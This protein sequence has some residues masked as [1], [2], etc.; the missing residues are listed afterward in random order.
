M[1]HGYLPLKALA[2]FLVIIKLP[3]SSLSPPLVS[4]VRGLFPHIPHWYRSI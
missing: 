4:A 1:A 3:H 2:A